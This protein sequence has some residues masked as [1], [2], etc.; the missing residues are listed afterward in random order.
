MR[1]CVCVHVRVYAH[2]PCSA[3]LKLPFYKRREKSAKPD[4]NYGKSLKCL[5]ESFQ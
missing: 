3:A 2:I 4:R 1:V 5:A